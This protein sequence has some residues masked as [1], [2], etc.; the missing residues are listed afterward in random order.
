MKKTLI[1]LSL[2][3]AS[4][5][6]ALQCTPLA[7]AGHTGWVQSGHA[8]VECWGALSPLTSYSRLCGEI[9]VVAYCFSEDGDFTSLY[10]YAGGFIKD[11]Y[12]GDGA[13]DPS[14]ERLNGTWEGYQDHC[15]KLYGACCTSADDG[16]CRLRYKSHRGTFIWP[17][18]TGWRPPSN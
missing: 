3:A 1:V 12:T 16:H 15:Q 8:D 18:D 7:V 4:I 14:V 13:A 11:G 17:R 10:H 5:L 6:L 9:N 2:A